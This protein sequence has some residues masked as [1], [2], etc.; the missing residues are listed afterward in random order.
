MSTDQKLN[1]YQSWLQ[2][3]VQII[4]SSSSF[5][6]GLNSISVRYI[7]Y[8]TM[9]RSIFNF[10]QE[11]NH[12]GRDKLISDSIILYKIKDKKNYNFFGS[13]PQKKTKIFCNEGNVQNY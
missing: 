8:F 3:K 4:V 10:F 2:R 5:D 11:S 6:I 9:P 12:A 7:I 13:I 1:F